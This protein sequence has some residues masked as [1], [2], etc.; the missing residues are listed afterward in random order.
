MRRL[1]RQL[2]LALSLAL[3]GCSFFGAGGNSEESCDLALAALCELPFGTSPTFGGETEIDTSSDARC[4]AILPPDMEK[5]IPELCVITGTAITIKANAVVRATG[6]RALALVARENLSIYGT[7]DVSSHRESTLRST[8][9]E[10]VGAGA[11]S[12]CPAFARM[13]GGGT[14]GGAGGA[15]G[16]FSGSGG[17]GGA[18]DTDDTNVAGGLPGAALTAQEVG[19]LHAG[20]AGQ[21]GGAAAVAGGDGGQGGGAVYLASMKVVQVIGEGKIGANGA[22]GK[23]GGPLAGGG[24]G[25]SGGMIVV[26]APLVIVAGLISANGGGGGEGGDGTAG[27]D[28]A[29]GTL[30]VSPARGGASGASLAKGGNGAAASTTATPGDGSITSGG[31]GGGSVGVV[32]FRT[33]DLKTTGGMIS[34]PPT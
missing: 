34:P 25:G 8:V 19:T 10:L 27:G 11:G 7:L 24:G 29:D 4:N 26:D 14:L 9:S 21:G 1:S 17:A 3:S 33:D 20:C 28:G 16:S 18:G 5:G 12:T 31:G 22:G 13:P 30:S 23:G 2:T 32:R 6:A 15:G